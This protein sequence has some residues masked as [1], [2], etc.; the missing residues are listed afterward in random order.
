[1]A[2]HRQRDGRHRTRRVRAP[3][4]RWRRLEPCPRGRR[5]QARR[6]VDQH[7]VAAAAT[8]GTPYTQTLAASG[9]TGTKTWTVS[10]GTLPAGLT[11]NSGTGVISGTRPRRA[12]PPSPFRS[13]TVDVRQRAQA[14]VDHRQRLTAGPAP[15]ACRA[16]P[17]RRAGEGLAVDFPCPAHSRPPHRPSQKEVLSW[18]R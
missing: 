12:R 2:D 13:S 14:A 10:T 3:L 5:I 1:M 11:L 7:R 16:S 18:D 15:R 9:G 8:V 17:T 4:L 6:T